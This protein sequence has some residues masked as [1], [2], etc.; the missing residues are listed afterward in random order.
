MSWNAKG[1]GTFFT[2]NGFFPF[3][4]AKEK[5]MVSLNGNYVDFD[6]D[7]ALSQE[8]R[9]VLIHDAIMRGLESGIPAPTV[10]TRTWK[11]VHMVWLYPE[12]LFGPQKNIET[13]KAVQKRLVL[14]FKGDENCKD[15]SRI[16]RV[17]GTLHLKDPKNPYEVHVISY[18]PESR[19]TLDELDKAIPQYSKAEINAKKVP[20]SKV[21]AGLPNEG[22]NAS[23][24][25]GE[26]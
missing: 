1:Y 4:P 9:D 3:G 22:N 13:W 6:T 18:K 24:Q 15:P 7:P 11:G 21:L 5:N 17:P 12:K 2:V 14:H 23:G 20:T 10:I 16:L 25:N 8:E 26:L 19:H